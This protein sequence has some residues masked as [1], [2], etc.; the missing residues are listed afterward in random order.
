MDLS[1]NYT[2]SIFCHRLPC[3]T[4]CTF[5]FFLCSM[6]FYPF[7]I[8]LMRL[9]TWRETAPKFTAPWSAAF[10]PCHAL[11]IL[12]SPICIYFQ[13]S[14][15]MP[16]QGTFRC[17]IG[18]CRSAACV[19]RPTR[20]ATMTPSVT[21]EESSL[22]PNSLSGNSLLFMHDLVYYWLLNKPPIVCMW[23]LILHSFVTIV[24]RHDHAYCMF[25]VQSKE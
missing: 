3:P 9:R 16:P 25:L 11:A 12:P 15:N 5:K 22:D 23:V 10:F 14:E 20:C 19:W 8:V 1:C 13:Y 18:P 21:D 6:V 2:V 24:A 17:P 4:D 7:S